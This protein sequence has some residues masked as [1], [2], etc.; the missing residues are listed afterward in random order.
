MPVNL[1]DSW[2]WREK[3]RFWDGNIEEVMNLLGDIKTTHNI[4]LNIPIKKCKF[5]TGKRV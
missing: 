2:V 5:Q 3:R 4:K 1:N